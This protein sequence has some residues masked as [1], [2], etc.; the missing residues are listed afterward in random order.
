[1]TTNGD[2]KRKGPAGK[3]DIAPGEERD[4][5][6]EAFE[7]YL[8]SRGRDDSEEELEEPVESAPEL[9]SY[10][11][12]GDDVVFVRRTVTMGDF[13]AQKV[14]RERRELSPPEEIEG[15]SH[16]F[17]VKR[18]PHREEPTFESELDSEEEEH[19]EEYEFQEEDDRRPSLA[20]PLSFAL[21][22]ASSVLLG[23][24]GSTHPPQPYAAYTPQNETQEKTALSKL[25]YDSLPV[26]QEVEEIAP[27]AKVAPPQGVAAN[28][29]AYRDDF[30]ESLPPPVVLVAPRPQLHPPSVARALPVDPTPEPT[31]VQVATAAQIAQP[32]DT[33]PSQPP[34]LVQ[35]TAVVEPLKVEKREN[36]SVLTS[37]PLEK[38]ASPPEKQVPH[39]VP[40]STIVVQITAATSSAVADKL[41]QSLIEQG[42]PAEVRQAVVNGKNFFRVVVPVST[43][44]EGSDVARSLKL[45][46]FVKDQPIIR[47]MK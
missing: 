28:D 45:L 36:V 2:Y 11:A 12:D 44:E 41:A 27:P 40:P 17:H 7:K 42:F 6:D 13:G 14:H 29:A 3:E 46:P 32:L 34:S 21:L 43:R 23:I 15:R 35:P 9:A 8:E 10:A 47:E 39:E 19:D 31:A 18:S 24:P 16:K 5:Y 38:K 30:I 25:N 26:E 4:L 22:A 20:I 1:V 33:L 37:P